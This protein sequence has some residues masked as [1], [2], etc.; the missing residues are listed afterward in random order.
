MDRPTKEI[1]NVTQASNLAKQSCTPGTQW[2]FTADVDA[3]LS[4]LTE[5]EKELEWYKAKAVDDAKRRIEEH[6]GNTHD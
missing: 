3:L 6:D 1:D 2:F 4:W 5:V